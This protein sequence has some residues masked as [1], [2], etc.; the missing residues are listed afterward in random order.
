MCFSHWIAAQKTGSELLGG[1]V[2]EKPMEADEA[3]DD[4]MERLYITRARLAKSFTIDVAV[5]TRKG[6]REM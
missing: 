3:D 1:R 2:R 4:K 6:E 5:A